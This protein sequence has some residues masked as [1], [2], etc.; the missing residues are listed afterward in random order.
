MKNKNIELFD[1]WALNGK[2]ISME[3]GHTPSVNRMI[4]IIQNKS[5]K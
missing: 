1:Q 2:D 5:L 3:K 4:E